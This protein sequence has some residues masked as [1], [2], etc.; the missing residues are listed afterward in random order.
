MMQALVGFEGRLARLPYFGYSLLLMIL[1]LVPVGIGISLSGG[2]AADASIVLMLA[3]PIVA[4]CGAVGITIKRLHDMGMSGAHAFWISAIIF[5]SI[6]SDRSSQIDPGFALSMWVIECGIGLWLLLAPGQPEDNQYGPVPGTT[7]RLTA[8]RLRASHVSAICRSALRSRVISYLD[9]GRRELVDTPFNELTTDEQGFLLNACIDV[10]INEA[11][12]VAR[13]EVT[14]TFGPYAVVIRGVR[15]V[16]FYQALEHDV[17]G[18]FDSIEQ[19]KRAVE[20][21][22]GD[23]ISGYPTEGNQMR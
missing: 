16:Y 21:D 15:R 6:A 10:L 3:G 14:R 12:E 11:P 4:T 5:I 19:A 1:G 22:F 7:D 18:P 17:I 9:E 8:S 13:Y 20:F 2:A 23:L